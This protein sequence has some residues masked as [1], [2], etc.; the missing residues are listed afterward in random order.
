MKRLSLTI[1]ALIILSLAT[2]LPTL[3]QNT[4]DVITLNDS[5][6]AIDVAITLPADTTGTVALDFSGAA[7]RLADASGNIV[8]EAA[9]ARLHGL[10]L[11]IAPNSGSHTLTVERLPGVTMA[12]VRVISLPELALP[13]STNLISGLSLETSQEVLLSLNTDH[14][15]D[16]INLLVPAASPGL[17]TATF[18][19]VGATA[20]LVDTSGFVMAES[21]GGIVDGMNLLVDPGLYQ[22][23]LLGTNVQQDAIVGV[24]LVS[25]NDAGISL[26]QM[27][28]SPVTTVAN[29]STAAACNARISVSSVNLRSGPGTGYTV[30]GYGYRDQNF[31]V[32]GHNPENNW[33]VVATGEGASAWVASGNVQMDGACDQLPTFNIPLRDA[34]PASIIITSPGQS[35]QSGSY[36]DDDDDDHGESHEESEHE[37]DDD[38]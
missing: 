22:L 15:G 38:D 2:V 36:H 32:G 8:F 4:A 6:P 33:V 27:P 20:Q 34:Q 3:A 37:N 13:G 19:G 29:T 5:T 31:V 35:A 25:A 23:T 21:V 1:A 17:I 11:N 26:M 16:T 12:S 9:D 24:R 14:P 28:E 30:L 7:V 10:A 18:P